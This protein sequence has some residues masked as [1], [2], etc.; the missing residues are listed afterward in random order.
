MQLK[1]YQC[2]LQTDKK[3]G[4]KQRNKRNIDNVVSV[5]F[6]LSSLQVP[7]NR[8]RSRF[9]TS[10]EKKLEVEFPLFYFKN[11]CFIGLMPTLS[12]KT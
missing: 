4:K 8:G 12:V 1:V 10:C 7:G 3:T 11:L 2:G 5:H 6:F 9:I